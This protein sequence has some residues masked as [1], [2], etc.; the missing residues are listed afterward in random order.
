MS[1]ELEKYSGEVESN[2]PVPIRTMELEFI[3]SK[4]FIRGKLVDGKLYCDKCGNPFPF[5]LAFYI[6]VRES[7]ETLLCYPCNYGRMG[8]TVEEFYRSKR[9]DGER[10]VNMKEQKMQ[11]SKAFEIANKL[12]LFFQPY[13]QIGYC[14]IAGSLR[15]KKP[16]VKDIELVVLPKMIDA[17]DGLFETKKIRHSEFISA[18]NKIGKIIKGSPEDGRYVQ[19]ELSEGLNLDLFIPQEI[20]YWR[21]FVIRTGSADYVRNHIARGWSNMGWCGTEDGLRLVDEC[22]AKKDRSGKITKWVCTSSSPALP[23]VWKSEAEFFSWLSVPYAEPESR[24]K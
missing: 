6:V 11:H 7:D 17:Q 1:G 8:M 13:C 18:V 3:S 10:I 12:Q 22:E 24:I 4:R 16:D 21:Q 5:I 14:N 20:D 19:I 9:K 2:K 23:P 15:R